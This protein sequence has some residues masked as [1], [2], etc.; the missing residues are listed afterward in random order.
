M[1][2]TFSSVIADKKT[3]ASTKRSRRSVNAPGE[4]EEASV[5]VLFVLS[6]RVLQAINDRALV[7]PGD[8]ACYFFRCDETTK[9]ILRADFVHELRITPQCCL[10]ISVSVNPGQ[11]MAVDL[12]AHQILASGS[13]LSQLRMLLMT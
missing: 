9:A 13:H 1:P 10:S 6:S 11:I 12:R 5:T 3:P 4:S 7:S 8:C 2:M